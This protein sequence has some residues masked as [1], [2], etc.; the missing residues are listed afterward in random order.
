MVVLGV[1]TAPPNVSIPSACVNFF[2]FFRLGYQ[3]IRM[4][5]DGRTLRA[6]KAR[7]CIYIDN[8]APAFRIGESRELGS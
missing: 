6:I 8:D 4:V 1:V 2:F 3:A 5:V 7:C